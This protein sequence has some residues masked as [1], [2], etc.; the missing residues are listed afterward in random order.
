[1]IVPLSLRWILAAESESAY[2]CQSKLWCDG[3][4]QEGDFPWSPSYASSGSGNG[5]G[6]ID[7]P[8]TYNHVNIKIMVERPWLGFTIKCISNRSGYCFINPWHLSSSAYPMI[9]LTHP[10]ASNSICP[11]KLWVLGNGQQIW[12]ELLNFAYMTNV[13]VFHLSFSHDFCPYFVPHSFWWFITVHR[14]CW[15]FPQT[16]KKT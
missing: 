12:K 3:A 14:N 7:A 15:K 16:S 2:F 8:P 9:T 10:M 11:R 4:L 13:A 6:K 1:M 5:C